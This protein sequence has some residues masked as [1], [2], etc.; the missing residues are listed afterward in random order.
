MT[1][2]GVDPG[3]GDAVWKSR[4]GIVLQST[5]IFPQLTVEEIVRHFASFYPDPLPVGQVVE[6]TGLQ[7]KRKSTVGK[8]SGGQRRRVDVALG[9]VGNP[10]VIFLDEPTTGFDPAA[11]RQAWDMVRG[12]TTLG[13]T[14]L[15]TTHYLDEAEHL[16][17]R[18]GVIISG[19][20]AALGKPAE[21]GDRSSG[22]SRVSFE[23]SEALAGQPL[24][25]AGIEPQII[26]Q[27]VAYET[28]H[29]TALVAAL[30]SW[31]RALGCDELPNLSI[32]RPSLEDVYLKMVA[33][34]ER[35]VGQAEIR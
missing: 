34:H 3:H 12:L 29:P 16:A 18:V 33:A 5:S 21:I 25:D 4:L 23:R 9:V 32:T 20:L 15:L 17:N 14:V 30:A 26:D 35:E 8:L 10:E 2:L 28:T 27:T 19:K 11:R 24:P 31:A 13:K 6:M 7:E 1:V 22:G